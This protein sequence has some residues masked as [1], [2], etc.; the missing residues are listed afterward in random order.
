MGD[1]A[2]Q[3]SPFGGGWELSPGRRP[4]L[5]TLFPAA[6]V[7]IA[8]V[9]ALIF[10]GPGAVAFGLIG[11]GLAAGALA[12]RFRSWTLLI[13]ALLATGLTLILWLDEPG[14]SAAILLPFIALVGVLLLA[15]ERERWAHRLIEQEKLA[16]GRQLDRRINELFSLQELGYVLAKSL[17]LDQIAEQVVVYTRR[18]LEAEGAVLVLLHEDQERLT[19]AAAEGSLQHLKG[20]LLRE[21][22]ES[23]VMQAIARERI[24]VGLATA[25]AP[26][27]L[28]A[29]ERVGSGAAAPLRAHGFT[30]GVIA[31]AERQGGSFSTEDLW[32]LSTVATH[33]AVA[34]ANSR[35]FEIIRRAKEEW[36]T[37][38]NALTEGVAVVGEQGR[39][40]RANPALARMLDVPP[41]TLIGQ[42]FWDT[43]I[44]SP[45]ST[46]E[47]VASIDRGEHPAPVL[48][49]SKTLNR[50][51]RL[52]AAPLAE[53]AGDGGPATVVL[54]EDVTEQQQ[55]EAQL[56]QNEKMAAVGQL[57]SGVAHELNNP[58][59][60]IAGLSEFLLERPGVTSGDKEHLKV[61]H[62][63]A[64]R[65]G[66]IVQNLLTFARKGAPETTL[67]D[68][69]DVVAR[70]AMLVVYELKL[71]GVELERHLREQ[72]VV[73]RGDRHELQQVLLN[74]LTNAVQA[75]DGLP[76]GA[77]RRI[78]I[79]TG[80][81]A[82]QSV[83]RVSDTG[84]G[85]PSP[86]VAQLFTPFFT[87]K[88]PGRGT[89]LGLSISYRIIES[90]GG[91]LSYA[92]GPGGG[93]Q[94]TVTLPAQDQPPSPETTARLSQ[95]AATPASSP[96]SILVVDDDQGVQRL[97]TTLFAQD[98]HRVDTANSGEQAMRLLR[99]RSY[100]VVIADRRVTTGAQRLFA[101][102]LLEERPDL[103]GRLLVTLSAT[104]PEVLDGLRKRS[105]RV[106]P[107]P[108]NLRDL[109]RAA[110]E[111]WG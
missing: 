107:K 3:W 14:T 20:Q 6:T 110:A 87:T 84:V 98:G 103:G 13:H 1:R 18:F 56:I 104:D 26:V 51:L 100:D 42:P 32:L 58:L 108:F 76:P 95:P 24:E 111:V 38:F 91:L 12:W 75:V 36:E 50:T 2:R 94:F 67:V 89:G 65:A 102:A 97:L 69:N 9:A 15:A 63:Q 17:Q 11:L 88:E 19:V 21:G 105:L 27:E 39:V 79:A 83:L 68:L 54:V 23:L 25:E 66:R 22:E 92:P 96:R 77:P 61:I 109:R 35:F 46:A 8:G 53:G 52:T 93:S 7:A 82:G 5:L 41:P 106:V 70:T 48:L 78:V 81:E 60:S 34:L 85:V 30:M 80:V 90:H 47:L 73:V 57:V 16:L 44:G 59:T 62:D 71:R 29:G 99:E 101:D 28:V 37:A 31:V 43:V 55:L 64:E 45:D 72:P 10:S 49:Q 4:T 33:V 40:R 86:L 74:L